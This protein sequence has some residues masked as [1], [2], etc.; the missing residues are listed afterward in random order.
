[1]DIDIEKLKNKNKHQFWVSIFKNY[2]KNYK[3]KLN[4][5]EIGCGY[6]K[7]TTKIFEKCNDIIKKY[8]VVDPWRNLPDW[9][10]PGNFTDEKFL[11]IYDEFK[12][13]TKLYEKKIQIYRGKTDEVYNDI[14]NDID[15]I[16]I[17]GDHTEYGIKTDLNLL[18]DKLKDGGLI[19]GCDYTEDIYVHDKNI[20]DPTM[21]KIVVDNFIR[22]YNNNILDFFFLN[23]QFLIEKYKNINFKKIQE[24]KI[25]KQQKNDFLKLKKEQTQNIILNESENIEN[26]KKKYEELKNYEKKMLDKNYK[27]LQQDVNDILKNLEKTK[28]ELIRIQQDKINDIDKT[29]KLKQQQQQEKERQMQEQKRQEKIKQQYNIKLKEQQQQQ[30]QQQQQKFN[31]II[32]FHCGD[33]EFFKYLINKFPIISKYKLIIS[34]YINDYL[35]IIKKLK[36]NII[37]IFKVENKGM[38][39]GPFLLSIKY[40]LNNKNVY[41][42]NTTFI[43]IHT[44]SI[45]KSESW[46]ESLIKDI[47]DV[48]I[49]KSDIPIIIGSNEF[50]YR[51]NKRINYSNIKKIFNRCNQGIYDDELFD[52]YFNVYNDIKYT[53]N[54]EN[55]NPYIDLYYNDQFYKYYEPDL[56]KIKSNLENHYIYHGKKE[57]HRK[58]NVNYIKNWAKKINLFIA[59][60]IFGFNRN[61]LDLFSN[62]NLDYEYSILEKGY[63]DN[64]VERNIHAWEYYFGFTTLL[65]NGEIH[66]YIDN[67]K[68]DIYKDKTLKQNPI[69]SKIYQPYLKAN[70]AF[71]LLSSTGE[72]ANSGGYRTIL[73]YIKLLNDNNYNIDIY[74][75]ACWTDIDVENYVDNTSKYGIPNCKNDYENDPFILE[76]FINYVEKYD[77]IDIEKNNYYIGFKC[78]RKY[79]MIV[80]NAWQTAESVYKNKNSAKYLLY[81]IQDREELFYP[82][83]IILQENALKTYKKDFIYYCI[84]NY[85]SDYF[86]NKLKLKN[87]YK[88][89]MCVDLS[90]YKNLKKQRNNSVVIP[91]YN[92]NKPG[93]LPHL[94]EKIIKI[95]S[96]NNII[97]YVYPENINILNE[98][99]INLGTLTEFELN[100]LYNNNKVGIIFSNTNPSRLG[101]EMFASGLNV[102]EYESEFTEFDMPEKYFTKI[103][104]EKNIKNIV[105]KL[106]DVDLYDENFVKSIDINCDNNNFLDFIKI[107]LCDIYI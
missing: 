66:G 34:Y 64:S 104:N 63:V 23:N 98:N 14:F 61:W 84:T 48:C 16:F 39:V 56:K 91:Y 101:Y 82:N 102:I 47:I 44:K 95:L 53:S 6:G 15:I 5:L 13:N 49:F 38:D 29:K 4:I 26:L 75:G 52:L 68:I 28:L 59:G 70:I 21:V 31:K 19:G 46:T 55:I 9:K 35:D 24:L 96:T 79:K 7:F 3:N 67:K 85:L 27:H 80:A 89:N 57:Y 43:K 58:A 37:H 99:V 73:K 90:I 62:Y 97:C 83:N 93:R 88:S 78:Q 60:T 12:T 41:D 100:E 106:F 92:K 1:M 42:D 86:K 22:D 87:I 71:F 40:L 103:K 2:Y 77:V 74:F 25:K 50:I 69:F 30:Q 36:L 32:I 105:K 45:K 54:P 81:I 17:D 51:Q 65:N 18:F 76:K 94:V 72:N 10:K 8:Y 33:I 107:H 20:Y 11:K